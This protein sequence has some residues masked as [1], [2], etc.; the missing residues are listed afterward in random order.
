MSPELLTWWPVA[1]SVLGAVAVYGGIRADLRSMRDSIERAHA[2]I[3]SHI[4]SHLIGVK[5]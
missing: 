2:R 3:D 5:K 4:D 1:A